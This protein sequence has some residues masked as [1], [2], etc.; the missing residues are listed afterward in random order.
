MKRRTFL[1][2]VSVSGILL[3]TGS[4]PLLAFCD[5]D[6]IKLTILHTN[7][8]HSRIEPFPMDGGRYQG[9]GGA[10]KRAG[11]INQ[12]RKEEA[13]L[14]LLDSGDIIQGTPYFNYFGGELEFKLM[15]KMRYDAATM[16]N[17]DFDAGVEGFFKQMQH[18]NFPFINC[19]YDLS[20][21]VL[22]ESVKP[23]LILEKGGIKVGILGV[24]IELKGL[25]YPENYKNIE[26]LDPIER[27]NHYAA[28]LKNEEGCDLVICLSHLGYQ[29]R[30]NKVSDQIFA[31]Q[32]R[33]IDLI[34]GGHTHT[35]MKQPEQLENLDGMPVL[36]NQA[37]WGGILLGRLDYYF[38][39]NTKNKCV[40]CS[41]MLIRGDGKN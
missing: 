3:A 31:R 35:F 19:N 41:N 30:T 27:A 4:F 22:H 7:D 29:Y 18:A 2:S 16:G 20:D 12:I 17:H 5:R 10:A 37:G 23:F 40:S 21:T 25:L 13:N 34:L 26:Y 6:I 24:G 9:M 15:S 8:V 32:S 36:I 28:L 14:L 11:L 38:E 1:K 33:N 39:R